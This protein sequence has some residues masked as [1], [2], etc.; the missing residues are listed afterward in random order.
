M[1][2]G[3]LEGKRHGFSGL[4]GEV[5][6]PVFTVTYCHFLK[7]DSRVKQSDNIKI[8]NL[9]VIKTFF[10]N[11]ESESCFKHFPVGKR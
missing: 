1:F 6:S 4:N 2:D 10:A 7:S 9:L 5:S 3:D 11:S 8:G